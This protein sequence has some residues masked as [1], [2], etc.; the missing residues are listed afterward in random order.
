MA[1]LLLGIRHAREPGAIAAT[2]VIMW[3]GLMRPAGLARRVVLDDTDCPLGA[4]CGPQPGRGFQF[5][6]HGRQGRR[7][8]SV[9]IGFVHGRA[10]RV[11]AP[12]ARAGGSVE[13]DS[14]ECGLLPVADLRIDAG[15][16]SGLPPEVA[17]A[18]EP[19]M[20]EAG[21]YRAR[22]LPGPEGAVVFG[23]QLLAQLVVAS[24]RSHPD[25]DVK[26]IHAVFA[27]GASGDQD[28]EIDLE[29]IHEGRTFASASL[30]IRQSSRV[31]V[32]A[33][34]LLSANE[35]DF[36]RHG[37]AMPA[38]PGPADLPRSDHGVPWI[39]VRVVGGVD[40]DDPDAIGPSKLDVWVRVP[41]APRDDVVGR[42]LL[43]YVSDGF[44]IGTAMRP[45]QGVGQRLA[46]KTI[47]TTVVTHTLSFHDRIDM[48]QWLL[49]AHESP[50]AGRGR[51][52]GRADVFATDG[53]LAASFSQESLIRAAER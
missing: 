51:A 50:H 16:G 40:T 47:A 29:A 20:L 12:V 14:H 35:P 5:R 2:A 45:H 37:C 11:T 28:L 3:R 36:I 43:A 39:D 7:P 27:R 41:S 1:Q 9:V 23:G 22:N 49:F 52:F 34:A 15:G 48:S 13:L 33:L 42:A 8:V 4:V 26:S 30:A 53:R 21:R 17:E 25:K 10:Q 46:H 18:L 19:Q 24:A 6:R 38:V 32:R 31:C 44:L